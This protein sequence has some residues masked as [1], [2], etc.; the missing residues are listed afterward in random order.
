[1]SSLNREKSDFESKASFPNI[2]KNQL[3]DTNA[4]LSTEQQKALLRRQQASLSFNLAMVLSAGLGFVGLFGI[5]SSIKEQNLATG[6]FSTIAF[7]AC[8]HSRKL[9][10]DANDRL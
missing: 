8:A 1:M 7:T 6:L 10:K 2:N 9:A 4:T 5:Y 3:S